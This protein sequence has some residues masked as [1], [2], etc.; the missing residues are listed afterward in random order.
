[1]QG[2]R[3]IVKILVQH[4]ADVDAMDFA[5]QMALQ[6]A[7]EH[8]DQGVAELLLRYGAD[9]NV[10]VGTAGKGTR[11]WHRCRGGGEQNLGR[12]VGET[13]GVVYSE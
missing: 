8:G 3:T 11:R 5:G 2:H 10:L 1:M 6:A 4:P 9:V 13:V 7:A 12:R